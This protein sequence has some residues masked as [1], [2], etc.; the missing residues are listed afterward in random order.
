MKLRRLTSKPRG[1]LRDMNLLLSL[2]LFDPEPRLM[3]AG[4][5][6][7]LSGLALH[8]W[9]K[10]CLVRNWVVTS[11]GPYRLVRHPFYLANFL[12]DFGVCLISTNPWLTVLYVAGFLLVYLPT[13]RKEEQNLVGAHGDAYTKYAHRVPALLP[14]RL[15][16]IFG[17]LD[18]AWS[19]ILREKELSRILRLLAIPSYFAMLCALVHETPRDPTARVT[20]LCVSAAWALL[21]NTSSVA[22]RKYERARR[23]GSGATT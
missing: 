7:F 19:N 15:H 18:F 2:I 1:V 21:L 11:C 5:A 10:G 16:A 14:Y 9:S 8:F 6:V 4:A 13:I 22:V 3:T 23:L 20:M 17:P 12:I